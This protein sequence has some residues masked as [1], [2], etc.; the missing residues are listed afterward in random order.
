MPLSRDPAARR[1]LAAL[2]GVAALATVSGVIV[3][4]GEERG[5]KGS[6]ERRQPRPAASRLSLERQVGELLVMSFDGT[7]VPDYIRRR[8]RSGQGSG[9]ILFAKN[10]PDAAT[11]T[12][13]TDDLQRAAGG[14]ALVSTDQEGGQ[15]RSVPFAAP[16]AS[17]STLSTTAAA[18]AAARAGARDLRR[19]GVNVNLAP[20][21][22]V[23]VPGS[24]V[25]GRAYPGGAEQVASLVTAAVEAHEEERVGATV[26][27]FPGLG[28]ATANTDDEP[29]TISAPA[30]QLEARDLVP[31]TAAI[32]AGV[33][34]V[35]ASHALYPAFDRERIASQSPA[36]LGDLL[37]GRLGF[38]GAV[39]T[40]SMEAQAV[41]ARSGVAEAAERS[42]E[43]GADLVLMTGSASWSLVQPRLLARA[44]RDPGFRARVAEAA[45][46]VLALKRRLGLSSP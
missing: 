11:L 28:P 2:C 26:K 35:M 25:A 33:P 3:G 39:I 5:E 29:V 18:G 36:V 13:L 4:S 15:I 16:Q 1:R 19:A 41:L 12:A 22:D 27:H 10:A 38:R 32:D 46:R 23:S 40:D 42:V 7:E 45:G 37:R 8:L 30:S 9:V 34:L 43:A 6:A 14:R 20:V 17:P 31:F 21:A 24:V 44:R